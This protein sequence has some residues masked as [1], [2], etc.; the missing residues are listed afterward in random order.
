MKNRNGRFLRN[1]KKSK[2]VIAFSVLGVV[3]SLSVTAAIILSTSKRD[4]VKRS[5]QDEAR[6]RIESESDV[7]ASDKNNAVG[8]Q[9]ASENAAQNENKPAEKI[10]VPNSSTNT[11]TDTNAHIP[12]S[13]NMSTNANTN[14]NTKPASP[15][16][17][18]EPTTTPAAPKPQPV[19][20]TY[21]NT[22]GNLTNGGAVASDGQYVYYL[23]SSDGYKLYRSKPD[24]SAKAKI[25]DSICSSLNIVGDWI[26]YSGGMRDPGIYK[27]KKD[28][29]GKALVVKA[30]TMGIAVVN[31]WIYY[32]ERSAPDSEESALYKVKT[33]GTGKAEIKFKSDNSLVSIDI[34]AVVAVENWIYLPLAN[35]SEGRTQLYR[36]K[37]DGSAVQKVLNSSPRFLSISDGWIYYSDET[38]KK[39]NKSKVDGSSEKT[40][41]VI[42]DSNYNIYSI[43][44]FN[45]N[46]YFSNDTG[47]EPTDKLGIYKM[48]TDGSELTQ[49]LSGA[50]KFLSIAADWIYF[51]APVSSAPTYS[52]G[53]F[54]VTIGGPWKIFK[55]KTDGSQLLEVN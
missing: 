15:P 29:S 34:Q 54:Q 41:Y 31:D 37:T 36:V 40:I 35:Q 39:L 44:V 22:S 53:V 25:S 10:E 14:T 24:G 17:S 7:Q 30:Q 19:S 47:S 26:Y 27:M 21:G 23:N 48:K 51:E 1:I 13:T 3:L 38:Y 18:S 32:L 20:Y 8:E 16:K 50:T 6:I 28:G 5:V 46:V 11:S 12:T 45:G 4:E 52:N 43:N 55:L 33:D 49:I 2:K 9:G 42:Q